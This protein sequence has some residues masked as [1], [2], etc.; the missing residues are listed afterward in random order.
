MFR[1][2]TI[3][4]PPVDSY[5]MANQL[6]A[7]NHWVKLAALIPWDE[8]PFVKRDYKIFLVIQHLYAQQYEMWL[9]K[10]KRNRLFQQTLGKD[11]SFEADK[12]LLDKKSGNPAIYTKVE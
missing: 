5:T 11:Y 4:I 9:N 1:Y 8:F 12:M 3:E 6:S 7:N 2:N 10:V